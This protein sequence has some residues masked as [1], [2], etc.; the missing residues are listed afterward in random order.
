LS[1]PEG[2]VGGP[3][4]QPGRE[5]SLWKGDFPRA[6]G[7][8]I[9]DAVLAFDSE[10][11]FVYVNSAALGMFGYS[12]E[13][14]SSTHFISLLPERLKAL[15]FAEFEKLKGEGTG[16]IILESGFA[17]GLRK[18]GTE[19]PVKCKVS[20]WEVGG[21][22]RFLVVARDLSGSRSLEDTL[23]K[24]GRAVDQS[25]VLV[26]I[27]DRE[28]RIEYV[29]PKFTEV[30]GY[31]LA[32]V[33][34]K[35]PRI[36][37]SGE[38]ADPL[39]KRLWETITSG[40]EWRGE[41][42]NRKKGGD[43]YWAS[44]TISP[45]KGPDGEVTHFVAIQEDIT[46][47]KEQEVKLTE[48]NSTLT[49]LVGAS[50]L[51]II[52]L[53]PSGAIRLWNKE[54]ERLFGWKED[55]VIGHFNPFIPADKVDT[56]RDLLATLLEGERSYNEIT[57]V[58]KDGSSIDVSLAAAPIRD[59]AG[60]SMGA[61]VVI[62]DVTRRKKLEEGLRV[63]EERFRKAFEDAPVG[64]T[65]T[66]TS[67]VYFKVNRAFSEMLGYSI[68]ELQSINF[69]SI[70]HPDDLAPNNELRRK[71]GAGEI[72]SFDL[73]KRYIHKDGHVVWTIL[74]V[75]ALHDA[76]GKRVYDLS[77]VQDISLR[78]AFEGALA[79][80]EDRYYT[81]FANSPVPLWEED[82]S[83]TKEEL[84][85][86]K[87]RGVADIR[88][89]LAGRP[90]EVRRLLHSIRIVDVNTAALEFHGAAEVGQ[91]GDI[92]SIVDESSYPQEAG[93]LA[94]IADGNVRYRAE[95]VNRTL[96]G[97]LRQADVLMLVPPG[98]ES[99]YA[100]VYLAVS[101]VTQLKEAEALLS[102]SEERFRLTFNNAAVG[103]TLSTPEGR[104]VRANPAFCEMLGYSPEE[105]V[106]KSWRD[107]TFSEDI[108][109][110][111]EFHRKLAA[112]EVDHYHFEKRYVKKGGQ[113]LW[114][115]TT[116]SAVREPSKIPV[117]TIS[118][119][120][121]IS[122]A[123][124]LAEQLK[125]YSSNLEKMVAERTGELDESHRKLIEA[126][127]LATIGSVAAQVG[128]DLRNPLTTI[129]TS[130]YFLRSVLPVAKDKK[131]IETMGQM[132]AAMLHAN[133]IVEDLLTY[134]RQAPMKKVTLRLDDILQAAVASVPVGKRVRTELSLGAGATVAGER[135]RLVRVFQNLISNAAD[136]MPR[137]G[138]L[139][140]SSAVFG[141]KVKVTVADTG[142]GIPRGQQRKLFLPLYTTKAQGLGMGLPICKRLVEA[143][144]GSISVKSK[145][146]KGTA[147][148]VVL[149]LTSPSRREAGSAS[150][151]R[152]SPR[153]RGRRRAKV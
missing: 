86:L 4:G 112:G 121:D 98:F 133:K 106:N 134:S 124:A 32:E 89:Y 70:T 7:E 66:E 88:E 83:K 117:F 23:R 76:S 120:E 74:N 15:V 85:A 2:V 99:N 53:D 39:Y 140:V 149:P 111:E 49:A 20:H 12:A 48:L 142:I 44:S 93:L 131:V 35:N 59:A 46:E 36:L 97:E 50:P 28:G 43:F 132:D 95:M 113:Q 122:E 118:M 69:Q 123:H 47:R 13:E 38:L 14:L 30:T 147:V 91:L 110:D 72:Q 57:A 34:G 17:F 51:A 94:T 139:S 116:V 67:G 54:A 108:P 62:A 31:P 130:L 96:S 129:N 16:S 152:G 73:E 24:L 10:G 33:L 90:D 153:R 126:E 58:R 87:E 107:F 61:M 128:H 55:E 80:S 75:S 79:E 136:A 115:R 29:N 151:S 21:E 104:L 150:A 18:N 84:E 77:I 143:H 60:L 82:F 100:K 81:L 1:V 68:E 71:L 114:A 41:F 26:V 144:G 146:G 65:I 8:F 45:V 27:T 19:F 37:K 125:E 9:D 105:L 127:R 103:M 138:R 11:R 137:G 145:L 102:A 64:M 141:R 148:T 40:R 56:F 92:D 25:P 63:S 52:T 101:D 135:S 5:S 22:S 42:H 6:L 109:I 119:A 3:Q 78:K